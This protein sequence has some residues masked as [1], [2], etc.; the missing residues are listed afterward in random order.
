MT[1]FDAFVRMISG[2][3]RLNGF[4]M[5]P[6]AAFGYERRGTPETLAALGATMDPAFEVVVV[7]P[8]ELD[9]RQ[10]RSQEIRA[11]VAA[12]DL[13]GARRL[14]GRHY[15]VTGTPGG[16]AT[17][18]DA[19]TL[20]F[21]MPVAL[22]PA[23]T[24]PVAVS[25]VFRLGWRPGRSIPGEAVVGPEGRLEIATGEVQPPPGRRLRIR[26]L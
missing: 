7:P 24:Y 22:P 13:A 2:R 23:G 1:P 14:L 20:T 4:L 11:A 19:R 5:T 3:T 26:F 17:D 12:G 15:A 18:A 21:P 9:G 6:D 10:V 8:Y 16:G 25:G